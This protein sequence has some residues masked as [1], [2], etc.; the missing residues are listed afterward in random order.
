[1][2]PVELYT[3]P[4]CGFCMMA[5]RLLSSKGI[6]FSEIDVARE[7]SRRQEMMTRANGGYTVP[8]IFIGETH[9]G[10]CDEL[11]A[12]ERAGKLDPLLQA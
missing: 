3:T 1:M 10:G 5:K 11:Y 9:V 6:S 8:Q 4:T 7:P 12:L 2:K